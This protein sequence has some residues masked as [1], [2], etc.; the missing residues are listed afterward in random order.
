MAG[1]DYYHCA[2]CDKKML[3]IHSEESECDEMYCASCHN[4]L[5]AKNARLKE[6]L[7]KQIDKNNGKPPLR[8]GVA[9]ESWV[10]L[11]DENKRLKED[12][13]RLKD[14]LKYWKDDTK[15]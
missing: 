11:Y 7:K 14:N 10:E 2:K 1:I 3:Y 12:N 8:D 5:Q 4:D 15:S 13:E 6:D 9:P